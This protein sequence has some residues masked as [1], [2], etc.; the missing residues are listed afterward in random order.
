MCCE[1]QKTYI[2]VLL[3]SRRVGLR[4][5]TPIIE[6]VTLNIKPNPSVRYN[7]PT[8]QNS[9]QQQ[10]EHTTT[11]TNNGNDYHRT[12]RSRRRPQERPHINRHRVDSHQ[13]RRRFDF[14]P[15]SSEQVLRHSPREFDTGPLDATLVLRQN[16]VRVH[17]TLVE[18]VVE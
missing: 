6:H 10:Q 8:L 12:R 13:L 5:R 3:G 17:F 18:N 9:E 16:G 4:L 2:L 7:A 11:N 14:P 15:E 1:L